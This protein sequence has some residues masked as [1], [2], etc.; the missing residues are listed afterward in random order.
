MMKYLRYKSRD[1]ARTPMQWDEG[2]NAGFTTGTPWI[3]VNPNYTRINAKEQL[4]REDSVFHYYRKLIELRKK[5]PII[6]YGKFELL[7]PEDEDIFMYARNYRDEQLLVLCNFS[8]KV[9]KMEIPD[10][11]VKGDIWISNYE[12]VTADKEISLRAYE[13]VVLHI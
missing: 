3:K 9:R 7:L 6:V 12:D 8:D 13:A 4:G 11:F 10:E 2:K 5:N 1:N